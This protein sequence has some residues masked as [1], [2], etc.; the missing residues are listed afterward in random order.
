MIDNNTSISV[1]YN[2]DKE[3]EVHKMKWF[4]NPK[5]LEELK[6]QYKKLACKHH[7]DITGGSEK[8]MKEINAEYDIL[9]ASLKNVHVNMKGETYTSEETTETPDEFKDVINALV[10]LPGIKIEIIGNWIWITGNTYPHRQVLKELKFRFSKSKTAWYFH[11]ADY[12]KNNNKT[13]TMDQIRDLFGSETITD[14]PQ[15]KLQIV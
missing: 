1:K 5:S 12:R 7:P 14:N 6:K 10:N 11:T 13:F 9:F 3:R 15:M 2:Q 4:S 8:D